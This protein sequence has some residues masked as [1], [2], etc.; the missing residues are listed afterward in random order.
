[1]NLTGDEN[2]DQDFI[3][4]IFFSEK[5][6]KDLTVGQV[7]MGVGVV[8]V[9]VGVAV[10]V[11]VGGGGVGAVVGVDKSQTFSEEIQSKDL[12]LTFWVFN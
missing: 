5:I 6:F 9:V 3:K 1:M 11:V 4:E 7:D 8:V 12:F 2:S 10:G